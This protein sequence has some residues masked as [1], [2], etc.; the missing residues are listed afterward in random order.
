MWYFWHGC[1]KLGAGLYCAVTTNLGIQSFSPTT[2]VEWG[3][4]V[5]SSG[6]GQR[7]ING[8]LYLVHRLAYQ[9]HYGPIPTG[10][11][12]NHLCRNRRCINPLHLEAITHYENMMHAE[13]LWPARICRDKTHC[14]RGH[15]FDADN[16]YRDRHGKRYCAACITASNKE[17]AQRLKRDA[18]NTNI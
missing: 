9:E 16:T 7:R 18:A 13:S 11:V 12:I 2:C 10:K 1:R 4:S 15:V 8:R 5:D 3:K 14:K 6:Y 17:R